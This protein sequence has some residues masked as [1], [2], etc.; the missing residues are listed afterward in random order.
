MG[1]ED[2]TD[3]DI[4]ALEETRAPESSRTFDDE[5]NSS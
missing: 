5:L 2:F 1:L 4:A 3:A